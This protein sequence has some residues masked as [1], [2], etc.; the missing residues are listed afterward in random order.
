M[1]KQVLQNW[2]RLNTFHLN[3]TSP[4]LILGKKKI[5]KGIDKTSDTFST[6]GLNSHG[7]YIRC[8]CNSAFRMID[9]IEASLESRM[10]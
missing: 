7:E 10:S 3:L 1:P 2:G 5:L 4:K 9:R 6:D 8:Y